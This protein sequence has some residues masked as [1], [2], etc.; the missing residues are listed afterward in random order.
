[1]AT[2]EKDNTTSDNNQPTRNILMGCCAIFAV[3]ATIIGTLFGVS[4]NARSSPPPPPLQNIAFCKRVLNLPNNFVCSEKL[5]QIVCGGSSLNT[6]D[7]EHVLGCGEGCKGCISS[8]NS[9]VPFCIPHS[10]NP[11][12][13]VCTDRHQNILDKMTYMKA[14]SD[15]PPFEMPST[16]SCGS[17]WRQNENNTEAGSGD[18]YENNN[19][20]IV[21]NPGMDCVAPFNTPFKHAICGINLRSDSFWNEFTSR[22]DSNEIASILQREDKA[23]YEAKGWKCCN[24]CV[25]PRLVQRCRINSIM[26]ES[27]SYLLNAVYNVRHETSC[28]EINI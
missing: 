8:S 5:N 22:D 17:S 19:T 1:M 3:T 12:Y 20:I 26:D 11:E 16:F 7:F 18:E 4:M 21:Q 25:G 27:L 2:I 15:P 9:Q 28:N 23:Q 10:I 14:V 24:R 13:Y 6:A